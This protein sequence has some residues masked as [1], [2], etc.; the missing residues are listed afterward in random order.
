MYLLCL[1]LS[2]YKYHHL[3]RGSIPSEMHSPR[4]M[5]SSRGV[6]TLCLDFVCLV[7]WLFFPPNIV[8]RVSHS[9]DKYLCWGRSSCGC[10]SHPSSWLQHLIPY[11]PSPPWFKYSSL[12]SH[13]SR[14]ITT[15]L[16]L[17]AFY[18]YRPNIHSQNNED[19][20]LIIQGKNRRGPQTFT[21]HGST[22]IKLF[23][24]KTPGTSWAL[25]FWDYKMAPFAAEKD[26]KPG[27]CFSLRLSQAD[28]HSGIIDI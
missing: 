10:T 14:R 3:N 2:P 21:E 1:C 17:Y 7:F 12:T 13:C 19:Y 28:I 11:A 25:V 20:K 27:L 24:Y 16:T 6:L 4:L 8:G 18:K 15:D 9:I 26:I 23:Y 5:P 22:F